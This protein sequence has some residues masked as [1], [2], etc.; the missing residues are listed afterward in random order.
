MKVEDDG[1]V[2]DLEFL[3]MGMVLGAMLCLMIQS[4]TSLVKKVYH[5]KTT[6]AK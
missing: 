1:S 5:S 2:S 3:F 4:C 6:G